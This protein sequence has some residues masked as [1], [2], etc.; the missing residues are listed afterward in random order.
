MT[1]ELRD[2]L[3]EGEEVNWAEIS[4]FVT[5]ALLKDLLR[6]DDDDDDNDDCFRLSKH[7]E[8]EWSRR[9]PK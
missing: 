1:Q 7:F 5:A 8:N 9:D 6:Y 4:V 2:R 3:D